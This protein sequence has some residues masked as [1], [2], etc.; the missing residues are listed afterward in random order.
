MS[1]KS[2]TFN[3]RRPHQILMAGLLHQFI[4]LMT[5]ILLMRYHLGQNIQRQQIFRNHRN[6]LDNVLYIKFRFEIHNMLHLK[7]DIREVIKVSNQQGLQPS[8]LYVFLVLCLF[9]SGFF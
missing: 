9:V 1:L 6:P 5:D 2:I 4:F 3:G 8:V 7:D